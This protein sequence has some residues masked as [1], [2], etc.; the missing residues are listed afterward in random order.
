MTTTRSSRTNL[1]SIWTLLHVRALGH[2]M[3][4]TQ[5]LRY[6]GAKLSRATLSFRFFRRVLLHNS[7]RATFGTAFVFSVFSDCKLHMWSERKQ[8]SRC[9][10]TKGSWASQPGVPSRRAAHRKFLKNHEGTPG[11]CFACLNVPLFRP[12]RD[13]NHH[14][15]TKGLGDRCRQ[16]CPGPAWSRRVD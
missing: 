13:H 2:E 3:V 14:G 4:P 16:R 12:S 6:Y 10:R 9:R 11:P 7:L 8:A 5:N 15:G 1:P